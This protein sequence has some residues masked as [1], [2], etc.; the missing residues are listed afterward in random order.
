MKKLFAFAALGGASLALAACGGSDDASTDLEA[1]NVEIVADEALENVTEEPVADTN[2]TA[3]EPEATEPA[4]Q[5]TTVEAADRAESVA[6]EAEAAAAAADA[7]GD[8]NVDE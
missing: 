3:P 6:A 5:Q 8:V 4:V 7:V 2:A 1:E